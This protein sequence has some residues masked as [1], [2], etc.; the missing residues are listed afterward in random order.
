MEVK[1]LYGNLHLTTVLGKSLNLKNSYFPCPLQINNYCYHHQHFSMYSVPGNIKHF[2][3]LT[4]INR[5]NKPT[6][7]VYYYFHF[8]HG[9]IEA[10]RVKT[11]HAVSAGALR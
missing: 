10:Q 9:K 7:E 5:Y 1:D 6:K 4:S 3:C 2:M 11:T 8:I